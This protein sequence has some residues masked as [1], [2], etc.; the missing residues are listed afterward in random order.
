[1]V[2]LSTVTSV[3]LILVDCDNC[4]KVAGNS[5]FWDEGVGE[6]PGE[7]DSGRKASRE[8]FLFF[9]TEIYLHNVIF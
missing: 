8:K 2:T 1:M 3:L 6:G 5:G 9:E 7:W 4:A